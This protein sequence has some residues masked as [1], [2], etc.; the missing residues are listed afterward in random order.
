MRLKIF[1][2]TII[3]LSISI[4]A[5]AEEGIKDLFNK[6]NIYY[7]NGDYE[8][9]IK[10]YEEILGKGYA[11]GNLYYNL[12]NSYFKTDN[13]GKAILCF[14]RALRFMPRDADLESNYKYALSLTKNSLPENP[15]FFIIRMIRSAA[16]N[17]TINELLIMMSS[18][19]FIFIIIVLLHLHFG[20][21]RKNFHNVIIIIVVIFT[22]ATMIFISK[23]NET[24]DRAIVIFEKAP[25]RFEPS[26]KATIYFTLYEGAKVK[27]LT[28]RGDWCKIKR[29]DG[30]IGWIEKSNIE[31]I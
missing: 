8:N 17:F 29:P 12:G 21:I 6:G 23:L 4:L 9:A 10:T 7:E 24:K 2:V 15:K 3:I 25:S 20:I 30:K 31:I 5:F 22:V 13:L 16:S 14:E 18:L 19:F 28:T 26:M 27:V 1:L 11:S